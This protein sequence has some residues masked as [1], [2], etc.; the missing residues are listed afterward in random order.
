MKILG[1]REEWL[2]ACARGGEKVRKWDVARVVAGGVKSTTMDRI[3]ILETS[4]T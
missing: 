4:R 3:N 2:M 1:E